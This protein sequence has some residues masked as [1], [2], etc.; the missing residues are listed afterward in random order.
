MFYVMTPFFPRQDKETDGINDSNI[1]PSPNFTAWS[2]NRA[3]A[4]EKGFGESF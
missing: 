1:L 3:T 4:L 2:M